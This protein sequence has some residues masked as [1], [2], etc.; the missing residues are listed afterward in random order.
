MNLSWTKSRSS[1]A[2]HVM[3]SSPWLSVNRA[4]GGP[5]SSAPRRRLRLGVWFG[6]VFL[7]LGCAAT[8]WAQIRIQI[9]EPGGAGVPIAVSPLANPASHADRHLAETFANVVALDLDLSGLF[10]VISPRAHIEQPDE[11]ELDHINF[12]NWSVLDALALVK[13]AFWLEGDRL[14]VEARLFD[15]TQR[16]QLG[17]R[18]YQGRLSEVRRMAHRFADQVM[19]YL[20]GEEG[21]FNSRIAFASNRTG[22][23]AKEIYVTDVSGTHVRRVTRDRTLSLAPSWSPTGEKLLFI[24]YK[25]GGPHPFI[26]DLASGR[27]ARISARVAY[28]GSWSPDGRRVAVSL[29]QNGNSDLYLLSPRG[30]LL[31]RLTHDAGIDVSPAWSPDGTQ[32]AFC[33]GRSGN[34]QIYVMDIDSGKTRRVTFTGGYNT[35]PDWS[36]KGDRIAY[37]SRAGGFRI[38]WIGPDGGAATEITRG[39][40]PS[41]SPDGRY[42]VLSRRGRIFM[43]SRD[44]RSS[45]QLTAGG[46][47]DTSPA[48]SPRLS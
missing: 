38:M 20:T 17:G 39:E 1:L 7:L 41:W 32:L 2:R 48:W 43:V 3:C 6:A 15:V 46:G 31:R 5:R 23:R 47:D 25:R 16:K 28:T 9:P 10:R 26:F 12:S 30:D 35:D 44:G 45:K 18:R 33:S 27:M 19:R 37:T 34:P 24:S 4:G 11:Y 42:L 29:D 14:T 13:G 36:P 22:G 8:T 40:H 21:P